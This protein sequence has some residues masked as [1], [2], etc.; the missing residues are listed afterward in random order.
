[1]LSR[2]TPPPIKDAVELNL[3]LKPYQYFELNDGVPVYTVDAGTQDVLQIEFVFYA[4]NWFD[5]QNQVAAATNSLL[6]NGTSNKS[7]FQINEYFE[8]Y[9]A[10]CTRSCHNEIATI[11]LSTLSKYTSTLLPVIKEMITDSIFAE[12]ELNIYKQN[13][14]QKLAVNLQKC[15]FVADRIINTYMYGKDHPYG[16]CSSMESI[17]AVTSNQ[18]KEFYNKYYLHG[19]CIIIA[20]GKI[21]KDLPERLNENFGDLKLSKPSAD[22]LQS[23]SAHSQQPGKYRHQVNEDGVQGAIRIARPFPNRH[24]PDFMKV[25]VLNNIFGG[26]FGSRL[27]N[28]IREDKGYTYGIYSYLQ[29]R[30]QQSTWLISTEAGKDVCEATVEE[31]YNEMNRLKTEIIPE[32]EL[33]VV[34]NYM[35]GSILGDL[36][37][38]FHILSRWKNLIL[39]N[40]DENFFYKSIQTIKNIS[41]E[42]LQ[43]LARKYLKPED[44]CELVVV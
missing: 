28:N 8:Y 36:D 12:G 25:M 20:A 38:P 4:G 2:T 37:G 14:K 29:N 15:D 7:A 33:Q 44:F 22:Y 35:M 40:L 31:V 3:Q 5:G 17:E 26:F 24:H 19:K 23:I 10:Y 32:D 39:N 16:V 30:I 18:L 13:T 43:E 11:S 42:E 1:M 41:A 9:G 27:M 34:R 6:K 21:P